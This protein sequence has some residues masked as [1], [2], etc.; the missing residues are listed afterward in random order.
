M[1]SQQSAS[2]M[3]VK[4]ARSACLVLLS[5]LL[6]AAGCGAYIIK[7]YNLACL[8]PQGHVSPEARLL[9]TQ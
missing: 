8:L 6:H 7:L 2:D 1:K 3:R 5:R 9:E 4:V